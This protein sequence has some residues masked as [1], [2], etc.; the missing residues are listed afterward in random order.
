MTVAPG[1]RTPKDLLDQLKRQLP[2]S[3]PTTMTTTGRKPTAG[4]DLYEAYLFSLVIEAAK[5]N[6]YSVRYE[7]APGLAARRFHLRRSPGRL[8]SAGPTSNMFTHAVLSYPT[9]PELEVH[10][11]VFVVGRSKVAHEADVLIISRDDADRCRRT[12]TDPASSKAKLVVEA[13]YYTQPVVLSTSREF[14]GLSK[15]LSAQVLFAC[16]VSSDSAKALLAGTSSVEYDVGVLPFREG[17]ESYRQFVQ[18]LLR[19]YRDRR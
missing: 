3:L 13:K 16:T 9:R 4:N 5:S 17:E 6:G 1:P 7:T 12:D 11:G 15:D 18:R 2:G 14:L 10:T 19:D 8:R